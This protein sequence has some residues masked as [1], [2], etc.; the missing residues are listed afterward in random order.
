MSFDYNGY[1][2]FLQQNNP[3]RKAG[4]PGSTPQEL[5]D[6]QGIWGDLVDSVQRGFQQGLGGDA[7]S[8]YQLT[9]SQ[10]AG[11][12]AYKLNNA[13]D[14]QFQ[15]MS[16]AGREA[17][18]KELLVEDENGEIRVG[19]GMT[20][21]RTWALQTGTLL[22]QIGTIVAGGGAVAVGVKGGAKLGARAIGKDVA[23]KVAAR[24]A[25]LGISQ[26]GA[27]KLG[28][29]AGT[30]AMAS[31]MRAEQGRQEVLQMPLEQLA[32]SDKFN[33]VL[34]Q[35]A[36][37]PEYAGADQETLQ[38]TARNVLAEQV[39]A[40]AFRD[41][42]AVAADVFSGALGGVA[43]GW[44]GSIMPQLGKTAVGRFAQGA[45][46]EGG[47]E[48]IQGGATQR[49]VNLAVGA[50]ADASRGEWD[51]VLSTGLTEGLLAG[52]L[53]GVGGM[54]HAPRPP[55]DTG[56][57]VLDNE[58][59]AT[60]QAL[61]DTM[62][63]TPI[64]PTPGRWRD[65]VDLD[66]PA[67]A[68]FLG[69]NTPGGA[70]KLGDEMLGGYRRPGRGLQNI[71]QPL[72]G[73]WLGPDDQGG[74]GG[75]PSLSAPDGAQLAMPQ[76]LGQPP[77]NSA[78]VTLASEGKKAPATTPKLEGSAPAPT[79][80][81]WTDRAAASF[82][83]ATGQMSAPVATNVNA[84]V[85]AFLAATP[86]ATIEQVK[87]VAVQAVRENTPPTKERQQALTAV[88]S[89]LAAVTEQ[90]QSKP[91]QKPEAAPA[92]AEPAEATP[93][94]AVQSSNLIE[95]TTG[96]GK[97]LRGV[98]RADLTKD[99]AKA[100]DPY[101]FQ[102][103]GGWF[104]R[105]REMGKLPPIKNAQTEAATNKA[106]EQ[107]PQA[108]SAPHTAGAVTTGRM[109]PQTGAA[110]NVIPAAP[111]T[112][113]YQA[114]DRT[115]ERRK[116]AVAELR[117]SAAKIAAKAQ[118][119]QGR[120][121][122][123]NTAKRASQAAGSLEQ[124][125]RDEAMGKTLTNLAD[126][127]EGGRVK[128]LAGVTNRL[129][130][131]Q[132][133][134]VRRRAIPSDMLTRPTFDGY[135]MGGYDEKDGASVDRFADK[136]EYPR[137]TLHPDQVGEAVAILEQI[138]GKG[139][140]EYQSLAKALRAERNRWDGR[141]VMPLSEETAKR[142]AA[143]DAKTSPDPKLRRLW[144]QVDY[145]KEGLAKVN[146]LKRAGI[147]TR[148]QLVD[149]LR[150]LETLGEK[151]AAEPRL[152]QLERELIGK[153]IPGYHNTT[154]QA[155][156]IVLEQANIQPGDSVLEPSAGKGDMA[157]AAKEAGADV[158]VIEI[159]GNLRGIL[160]EKGHNVVAHDF[161]SFETD[162]RY[163]VVL[164]NPPF[165][166]GQDMA[167]TRKAWELV[168][169]GGRLVSIL[170]AGVT[171]NS[172]KAHQ[173]FRAWVDEMGG[174][175][176]KLPE[177]SFKG[178]DQSTGTNAVY[179]VLDKPEVE[180][181]NT[182]QRHR[183][184][185]M[186]IAKG[187]MGGKF[188][189]TH[190]EINEYL[191][192]VREANIPHDLSYSGTGPYKQSYIDV[193]A[194]QNLKAA[195]ESK[196][197]AKIDRIERENDASIA[198]E[199]NK[200]N[201]L[202]TLG[203]PGAAG[204]QRDRARASESRNI[205]STSAQR[206][207]AELDRRKSNKA[208]AAPTAE[209]YSGVEASANPAR[210]PATD[211]FPQKEAAASYSGI[212][213]SGSSRA[214]ADADEFQAYLDA[215][216]DA[217][218]AAARSDA[219]KAAVDQAVV[220]LRAE[221][222]SQYRRLMNVRAATYSGYVA[223]RSGINTKQA[224]SRNSAYDKAID[225]FITW[226]KD[227]KDR[228]RMAALDA[229]TD[230]EKGDDQAT[231]FKARE[232]MA[233]RERD[234]DLAFIRKVL[235]WKKGGEPVV[236]SDSS[237]LIGV[238]Y[239]KR[240]YPTSIKLATADGE[241][242]TDDKFD[243]AALFRKRSRGERVA[244][245][246]AR[247]QG[248][249]DAVRSEAQAVKESL[250][251]ERAED[252]AAAPET[253]IEA[254]G[255]GIDF[256]EISS[257]VAVVIG[258]Q[259][260][261]I[262]LQQGEQR[263]DGTGY[264]LAHIEARHGSQI[265]NAG[266]DSVEQFVSAAI[267]DMDSIWR[268]GRTAQ[269]VA[270]KS[271]EKGKAVFIELQPATD[272]AGDFYRVNSAF[273]VNPKFAEKKE[274]KEGWERLWSRY[275]VSAG[276]SGAAG[277]V[278]Q[279]PNAGESAP[280]VSPQ[281][282]E[283]IAPA[284]ESSKAKL[285]DQQQ[286][287]KL[288]LSDQMLA[289]LREKYGSV[290]NWWRDRFGFGF[291][292]LT[293]SE[294]RYIL[295]S[296]LSPDGLRNRVS[297]SGS[298][299]LSSL[300]EGSPRFSLKGVKPPTDNPA[301]GG[302]SFSRYNTTGQTGTVRGIPR[303]QAE[304]LIAQ[305][306]REYKGAAGISVNV[307]AKQGDVR[308]LPS[309][310]D[311]VV[312]A[313]YEDGEVTVV[314]E[315]I[316]SAAEL[317]NVLRHEILAHHGLRSIIN[318]ADYKTIVQAVLNSEKTKG[319]LAEV[320]RTVRANYDGDNEIILAEE[321]IAHVAENTDQTGLGLYWDRV[322][323]LITRAL[324]NIG[325]L[326]QGEI[327]RTEIR[328]LIR[329]IG[330]GMKQGV[331]RDG[332]GG[333]NPDTRYSRSLTTRQ[334]YEQRIDALLAGGKAERQGV[335]ILD[336]SDVLDMLGFGDK[337]LHLQESVVGKLDR[338]SGNV[339]HPGMT[340]QMWKRVP[341]WI[342]NPVAVF[343]SQT[344]PGALVMFAPELV[345]GRPVRVTIEPNKGMGGLDVHVTTNAYEEGG[346]GITPVDKWSND[347]KAL[348]YL[349]QKE[350]P[351]FGAR[352][353]LRLP[354][355]VRQLKGY[356]QKVLTDADLVKYRNEN[357]DIRF[358]KSRAAQALDAASE[359]KAETIKDWIAGKWDDFTPA[360]LG[361]LTLRH[362]ADI[363]R[364]VLPSI[365]DYLDTVHQ[366]G[367]K[368]NQMAERAAAFVEGVNGWAMKNKAAA[369]A[370]FDLM[371]ETTVAGV[372]P[373][374]AFARLDM[375]QANQAMKRYRDQLQKATT[376]DGRKRVQ[377]KIRSLD[378]MMAAEAGRDGEYRKLKAKWDRL[379]PEAK[380]YYE[381]IR[382][383]YRQQF[384]EMHDT[385]RQRIE[386]SV[387]DG[388]MRRAI[389]DD[390]H[391]TMT[392]AQVQAPYFPLARF[393]EYWIEAK[394]AKG[395]RI[396]EMFDS[397]SDQK[398]RARQM[399]KEGLTVV[400]TGRKIDKIPGLSG[401]S[402]GFV[403]DVMQALE[404]SGLG[405]QQRDA[406]TDQIYQLYLRAL[407]D[408][409]LRKAFIH[410][411]KTKGYSADA[412]RS[413]ASN[414]VR[415]AYQVSRLEFQPTLDALVQ[416]VVDEAKTKGNQAAAI[417]NELQKR[418]QWV[419]N[420]TNSK[421]ANTLTSIGFVWM[422]GVSPAAALVNL[423]QN[424]VV[425]LPI[426]ASKFGWGAATKELGRSMVQFLREGRHLAHGDWKGWSIERTLSGDELA[427]YRQLHE[428]GVIDKT[429]AHDLMGIA[430]G[431]TSQYSDGWHKAMTFVSALFH[432]AEVANRETTAM[433]AYRLARQQGMSHDAAVKYAGDAVWDGHFD[434]SNQNRARYM[435]KDWQKVMLQF[436]QYGL[437][438]MYYLWRNAFL[439]TKGA[440]AETKRMA[441]TQLLGT[442]GV[443]SLLGG[444]MALPLSMVFGVAN[445]AAKAF[446]DD[447]EPWDAETE[448]RQ[449]VLSVA[450]EDLGRVLLGGVVPGID[451][452]ARIGLGSLMIREPDRDLE[453]DNLW[454]HYAQQAMGPVLGGVVLN[455]LRAGSTMADGN[456]Y[457]GF[458]QASPKFIKDA[459]KAGRYGTEGAL[460]MKG[461][462]ILGPD[463][464]NVLDLFAQASGF[465][466]SKM[467]DK[468]DRRG[469]MKNYEQEILGRRTE[470]MTAYYMAWQEKDS[471]K[472][473]EI[474]DEI[475]GFNESWPQLRITRKTLNQS[476]RARERARNNMV[477]GVPINK[478][479]RGVLEDQFEG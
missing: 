170:G 302:V 111:S 97:T 6:E 102:K 11:D 429:N 72:E 294:A 261:K 163:D 52:P 126:A 10:L 447:D 188:E 110:T 459:M 151:P 358:S 20:D 467:A 137:A 251:V 340:A 51:K 457:R 348:L 405:D 17:L 50:N 149:A 230:K 476:R 285:T 315:N 290:E 337:P 469:A 233:Q 391:D 333:Q 127:I 244:D 455:W 479:L 103:G 24:A 125:R 30:T 450:G 381:Q 106:N 427:A 446:G 202:G 475:R 28:V 237:K 423:T 435:Q 194:D 169:P 424:A 321:V 198:H 197:Q 123:T 88:R 180:A 322:V 361:A 83:G 184:R 385:L 7:E 410:R 406:L 286:D 472:M 407:P 214:K 63:S 76:L 56:N 226:Q 70:A 190:K 283:S 382:D 374:Q 239:D 411:R 195:P 260:G 318:D 14:G 413:L 90:P 37:L 418:H 329:S 55:A 242:L 196:I 59:N 185:A 13:A 421:A 384:E 49:A 25:A 183:D 116:L 245:A 4:Q 148:E 395:D 477:D 29:T 309:K 101:T 3:Y 238:N 460:T 187:V 201:N 235:S 335:K 130:V 211:E 207:Q 107:N 26:Q 376:A 220:D 77:A 160:E 65:G 134:G 189:S 153:K 365:G 23:E 344:V 248:L 401:A 388:A 31:G 293:E 96:K 243:L 91:S 236:F 240:G 328:E 362:L 463:G 39:A 327:S 306:L 216:R 402:S 288:A 370:L 267:A 181:E 256:G 442:L 193:V 174:A 140:K 353:G 339:K 282:N 119:E 191:R 128:A 356:K 131:E 253:F 392:W 159:N 269:I 462:E 377:E 156:A 33:A 461:D 403:N 367:A 141:G 389:L 219:Q 448:F 57:P 46:V 379:T 142:L 312:R 60:D 278:G 297:A 92:L 129:Q 456:I 441:R 316:T 249:V 69:V 225:T 334:A 386:Q 416:S 465:T 205:R 34:G 310:T 343:R 157:D 359:V 210:E 135:R 268:P 347:A 350:S 336:R 155:L 221:Y 132:L 61:T 270:I 98:V 100:V 425:A 394:D 158:D 264:G 120:D 464:F 444:A 161:M 144:P 378:Q 171:F 53:G 179:L 176:E 331:G 275:P 209:D 122:L 466:P 438:M 404:G 121:R 351:S 84:A 71:Q 326:P 212:S 80:P 147:E 22:G 32:Q 400:D 319:P 227:N 18:G 330:E 12:A 325:L 203:G 454:A 87:N 42:A 79:L 162:K 303:P 266:F 272:E 19:D 173:E 342:E 150:E 368:R 95:H 186:E 250:T 434:Y 108:T 73:E 433:A 94:T 206:M 44:M 213:H 276:A 364:R 154:G 436:K 304:A 133:Q 349:D 317:K 118:A 430:E 458:E 345:S 8:I 420:P 445:A 35:L 305:F 432:K 357:P 81:R 281:S 58:I 277:F 9:G 139:S 41:P 224:E 426:L 470:L 320:W 67:F 64:P 478:S 215:A 414:T 397:A 99:E 292:A 473:V 259:P 279:T 313:F 439:A 48:A 341:E 375:G 231:E 273:P 168:K 178:S 246:A 287:A 68:R 62:N 346:S 355:D 43:G 247:I 300:P 177:G 415:H 372:D 27:M 262:R 440:D 451:M 332:D 289:D 308:G 363:G 112:T 234:S 323:G 408:R 301:D 165:E 284:Q 393:G 252:G 66:Q 241:A 166:N 409:S 223:G 263:A 229:R 117:A 380:A 428:A 373:S 115:A 2:A 360:A 146:R 232:D 443:T 452:T 38:T 15:Q 383:T 200:S 164:M 338:D 93:V 208:E 296:G 143:I 78:P 54:L 175:L 371:H 307:A 172:S 437:N 299:G 45:L 16:Q 399:G 412:V 136:V 271:K 255:G 311:E 109:P 298:E 21:W 431:D 258:R 36:E 453:S 366:M 124:A 138:T 40:D 113:S 254:P 218:M 228:A 291:D 114:P 265:R 398:A 387:M 369:N 471:K 324:R 314:L 182:A 104:I 82:A 89:S 167:H 222:L 199:V 417:A 152:K 468:Y 47:T 352:S 192:L 396:F 204:R 390:M 354:R 75:I 1:A 85:D 145:A 449:W 422:L 217:G 74:G 280:T 474:M 86:D 274:E 295:K 257:D 419:M 105:E 5:D